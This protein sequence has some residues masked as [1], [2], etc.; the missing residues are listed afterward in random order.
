MGGKERE[1]GKTCSTRVVRAKGSDGE[2][3]RGGSK[4]LH[5]REGIY[6]QHGVVI[7]NFE[8]M[9]GKM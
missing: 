2:L 8:A 6:T 9:K 4:D 7:Y 1:E 5:V 3:D